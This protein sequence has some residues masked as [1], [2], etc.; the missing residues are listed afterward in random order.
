M[1]RV[2]AAIERTRASIAERTKLMEY[3]KKGLAQFSKNLDMELDEF[4]RFQELK[5]LAFAEGRLNLEEAQLVYDYL[6]STPETFNGQ[7][8]EVKVV[9]TKIL[10]ELLEARMDRR[11]LAM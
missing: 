8:L 6:G 7:P 11:N 10:A 1:N 2:A 9:L 4:V 5:S 3:P